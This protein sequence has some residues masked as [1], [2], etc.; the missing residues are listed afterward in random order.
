MFESI[1]ILILQVKHNFYIWLEYELKYLMRKLDYESL[2]QLPNCVEKW[3]PEEVQFF[4]S[5]IGFSIPEGAFQEI[6]GSQFLALT[7]EELI[8]KLGLGLVSSVKLS[9]IIDR[10]NSVLDGQFYTAMLR[11]NSIE[12]VEK[13]SLVNFYDFNLFLNRNQPPKLQEVPEKRIKNRKLKQ[14][15]LV[16]KNLSRKR[17][18]VSILAKLPRG[19]NLEDQKKEKKA[20]RISTRRRRRMDSN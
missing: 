16:E 13:V 14:S 8:E 2:L 15:D 1:V 12:L 5:T 18:S 6:N 17:R 7:K 10:L 4:A 20:N 3:C 19:K 11:K 9:F